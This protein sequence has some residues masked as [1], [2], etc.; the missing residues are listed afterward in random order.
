MSC[1]RN[2]GVLQLNRTSEDVKKNCRSAR[3]PVA[4]GA[5]GRPRRRAQGRDDGAARARSPKSAVGA[6]TSEA[7][8]PPALP[9][10]RGHEGGGLG[11]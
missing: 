2:V 6:T 7:K 1:V 3:R 11:G 10:E 8:D 9:G 5:P 4:D